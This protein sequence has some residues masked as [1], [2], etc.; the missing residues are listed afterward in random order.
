MKSQTSCAPVGLDHLLWAGSRRWDD[1]VALFPGRRHHPMYLGRRESAWLLQL[2]ALCD[3]GL[4][5]RLASG[6]PW[7]NQV[8]QLGWVDAQTAR[9][10][11]C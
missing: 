4:R 7:T 10:A 9:I 6:L 11:W 1:Q 2:T 8:D 3:Q 5:R